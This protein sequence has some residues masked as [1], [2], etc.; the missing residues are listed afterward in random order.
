MCSS[1]SVY[2]LGSEADLALAV[3]VDNPG[4]DAFE[5]IVRIFIP[6]DVDYISVGD[7]AAPVSSTRSFV[8]FALFPPAPPPLMRT[9]KFG[10]A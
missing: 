10:V 5:A 6:P 7:I 4:E 1:V 8:A 9:R 3:S 2:P